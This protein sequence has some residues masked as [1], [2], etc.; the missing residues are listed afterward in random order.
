MMDDPISKMIMQH[1]DELEDLDAD[2]RDLLV[3]VAFTHPILRETAPSVWIPQDSLGVSDDEVKRTRDQHP[4]VVI[5]NRG[6]FFNRKLKVDVSRPPPD[7][8]E[9]ALIMAEL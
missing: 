6:A 1:N 7:M 3:S 4:A 5:E 9:F 8:S 2:E